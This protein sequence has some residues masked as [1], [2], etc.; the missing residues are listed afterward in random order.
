MI[1]NI[2]LTGVIET[3]NDSFEI[4]NNIYTNIILAVKRLS[5]IYDY[6][7]VI[8]RNTDIFTPLE[9]LSVKVTGTVRTRNIYNREKTKLQV[10]V[11]GE[12]EVMTIQEQV[13]TKDDI[14]KVELEGFICR[15]IHSRQT[16][17][18]KTIA[19]ITLAYNNTNSVHKSYYIPLVCFN[20]LARK[21][22]KY[23][24]STVISI[25]GRF[26]SRN[27]QKKLDE[28]TIEEKVAYEIVCNELE[29]IENN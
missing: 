2:I 21:A 15:E 23:N 7:P 20:S 14:N 4:N 22:E 10:Y 1:N 12:I 3:I 9:G 6:I 17:L 19:D 13:E 28:N 5:G 24:I 26:Q 18:G 8:Y 16:P 11:Y 25:K 27:Y 29:V